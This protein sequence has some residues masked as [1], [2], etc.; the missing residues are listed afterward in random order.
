VD[1]LVVDV[2][3]LWNEV[4]V[5]G[6]WLEPP[7]AGGPLNADDVRHD[8]V[9]WVLRIRLDLRQLLGRDRRRRVDR[10][11]VLFFDPRDE[12][13]LVDG[14]DR[15]DVY[16]HVEFGSTEV[17][18]AV[19]ALAL[20][21]A[22]A[23]SRLPATRPALGRVATTGETAREPGESDDTGPARLEK[24]PTIARARSGVCVCHR[25]AQTY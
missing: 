6:E 1:E 10:E 17:P 23:A 4:C 9:R 15:P 14:V 8:D 25:L 13:L 20:V 11:V 24:R 18:G 21:A 12:V 19:A 7:L 16:H 22:V 5:V 3:D 2:L